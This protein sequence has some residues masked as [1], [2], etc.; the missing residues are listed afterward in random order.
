MTASSLSDENENDAIRKDEKSEMDR[1]NSVNKELDE[2]SENDDE[3]RIK[4]YRV[5]NVFYF[6]KR[7]FS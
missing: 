4:R 5:R 1:N 3:L 2:D 7:S 6:T